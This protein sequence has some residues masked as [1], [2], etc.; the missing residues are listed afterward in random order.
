MGV[1]RK[2]VG[3][4]WCNLYPNCSSQTHPWRSASC[5]QCHHHFH[6]TRASALP[7]PLP[8]PLLEFAWTHGDR[9]RRVFVWEKPLS[10]RH[11]FSNFR[12][13]F[14]A[15]IR[16]CVFPKISSLQILKN[17]L[18]FVLHKQKL[19]HKYFN[20]IIYTLYLLPVI[21]SLH[22][23]N[24]NM[25]PPLHESS[26]SNGN[27]LRSLKFEEMDRNGRLNIGSKWLGWGGQ[28]ER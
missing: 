25:R 14:K 17:V 27:G 18:F 3:I 22:H 26:A 20:L 4:A 8:L 15:F 12:L 11:K 13:F 21:I 23:L 6:T 10:H 5:F 24:M 28:V 1:E 9:G 2:G 19:I 7:L 16:L